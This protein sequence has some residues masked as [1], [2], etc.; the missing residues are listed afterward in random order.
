MAKSSLITLAGGRYRITL[1]ESYQHERPEVRNP[2][3]IWYEQIPCKGGA[4]ISFYS[5][6]PLVLQLWTPRPL[7]AG[8]VWEAIKDVSGASADFV[9]DGEAVLRFPLE[10]LTTV[11]KMAG[12]RKKR[13]LSPEAKARLI[14]LGKAHRFLRKNHGVESEKMAQI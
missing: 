4:F 3:R 1:D 5:L 6:D 12:A 7:N 10:A 11:A 14:E 8:K 9:F 2:D 13:R